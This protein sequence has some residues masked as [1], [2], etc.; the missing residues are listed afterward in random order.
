MSASAADARFAA[1]LTGPILPTLARL[2]LPVIVV[3]V[4]QVFVTILEAYWVSRLGTEAVAGV[5]LVLPLVLLMGTMSNGGIGGGVASAIARAKGAGDTARANALLWHAVLIALGFGALF[6]VTILLGGPL[7]YAALGARGGTLTQALAF[8]GWMFGGS[9]LVWLVNLLG[10]ALRGAGEVKLP[11]KVSLIGAAL[12]VPLSPLLILGAGPLPGLGVAGA[13]IATLLYYLGALITYVIWLRR[14]S[15]PL[16]LHGHPLDADPVRAIMGVGLVS[17]VGTILSSLTIIAIT[18]SVGQ[19]GA[20]ALAGYGI[21]SRVDSLLVPLLFGLGTGVVTMVA[22][23]TG[24]GQHQRAWAVTRLAAALGFCGA[25]GIGVVLVIAPW[26]WMNWFTADAAVRQ[27]GTL[28]FHTAG[29]VYGFFG[30]GLMLYFAAQGLGRMRG[31]LLAAISRLAITAGGAAWLA[32][33]HAPL[34][35]VYLAAAVG[36]LCF[37][38]INAAAV[39]RARPV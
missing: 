27:A 35:Q 31:P 38:L 34:L 29:P 37:G 30:M 10:A 5:A 17:A 23:A 20:Q 16:H 13:G 7:L 8:S 33:S 25:A 6:T 4:A 15:G 22:A 14:G 32:A 19:Y 12:L 9:I 21:A 11:A 36:T 24:A 3:I 39:W 18:G 2:T 28:W 1:I 26:L